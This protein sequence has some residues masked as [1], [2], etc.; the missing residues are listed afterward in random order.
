[1]TPAEREARLCRGGPDGSNE[2]DPA[3]TAALL[4]GFS[5]QEASARA[6]RAAADLIRRM[7]AR[8]TAGAEALVTRLGRCGDLDAAAEWV[9]RMEAARA[10]LRRAYQASPAWRLERR[11]A[12]ALRL[13]GEADVLLAGLVAA[14]GRD[15]AANGWLPHEEAVRARWREASRRRRARRREVAGGHRDAA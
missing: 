5:G 10:A 9:W 11:P 14:L 8:D 2:V 1:M 6:R 3:T 4:A 15:V 13:A 7:D 12:G